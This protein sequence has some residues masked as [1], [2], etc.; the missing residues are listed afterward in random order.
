MKSY[1]VVVLPGDGVGPEIVR[2]G[3]KVIRT[4]LARIPLEARF[5]ELEIG[6]G[7]Y[8]RTGTAFT[9]KKLK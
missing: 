3:L 2:E 7:R 9:A 6:A 8:R 1:H 4:A 5:T